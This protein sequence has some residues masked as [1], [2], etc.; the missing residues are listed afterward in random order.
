MR[1]VLVPPDAAEKVL[2]ALHDLD[3]IDLQ[4]VPARFDPQHVAGERTLPRVGGLLI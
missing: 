1:G 2:S 4:T 3:H